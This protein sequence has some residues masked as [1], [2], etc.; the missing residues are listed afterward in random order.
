MSYKKM[1]PAKILD[2]S[3]F[4]IYDLPLRQSLSKAL[5]LKRQTSE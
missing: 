3:S 5:G 1:K 4:R 2:M